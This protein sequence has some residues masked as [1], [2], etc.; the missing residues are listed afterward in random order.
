[1]HGARGGA[2]KGKENGNYKTGAHTAEV[3]EA[4]RLV[5]A[6]IGHTKEIEE[7][8]EEPPACG[9]VR[10]RAPEEPFLPPC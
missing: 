9:L 4:R 3:I 7:I 6:I 2:R 10:Y 1:M 5:R 8:L